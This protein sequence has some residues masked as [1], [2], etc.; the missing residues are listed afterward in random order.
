LAELTD[1]REQRNARI[2]EALGQHGMVITPEELALESGGG[3]TGRPHIAAVMI[4]KGFV[5]DVATAFELWLGRGRPGYVDRPR[6]SPEVAIDLALQS[7]A[8]PVLAHPHTLGISRADEMAQLLEELK[9]H[10]LVG[11][12]ALYSSYQLHER[13]GYRHLARRFGLVPS[14]GSDYHGS[15]KAGLDLGVGYGDLA[16]PDSV[17]FE[18]REH[19]RQP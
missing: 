8:V 2:L 10:G 9:G 14:G 18:L 16:V 3:N 7:G 11:L 1:F 5:P 17:M 19:A 13:E 15:Y 4:A 12:E 6:L